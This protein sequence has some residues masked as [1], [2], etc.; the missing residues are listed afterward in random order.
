MEPEFRDSKDLAA[1][2]EPLAPTNC[3]PTGDHR[4]NDAANVLAVCIS[5]RQPI[6]NP[7]P[8]AVKRG[9]VGEAEGAH[10]KKC[11]ANV[12]PTPLL[13][14]QD[15]REQNGDPDDAGGGYSIVS[16]DEDPDDPLNP[17]IDSGEGSA[18][19]ADDGGFRIISDDAD[20]DGDLEVVGVAGPEP[21]RDY[22][23]NREQCAVKQTTFG[24]EDHCSNCFCMVC[25]SLVKDCKDWTEHCKASFS[26]PLWRAV[27]DAAKAAAKTAKA[28]AAAE[29]AL[30]AAPEQVAAWDKRQADLQDRLVAMS[31]VSSAGHQAAPEQVAAWDKRQADLQDRLVAMSTVTGAAPPPLQKQPRKRKDWTSL[32]DALE[33]SV[34]SEAAK[35]AAGQQIRWTAQAVQAFIDANKLSCTVPAARSRLSATYTLLAAADAA[36]T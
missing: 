13:P 31:T 24:T 27:R 12:F 11:K 35:L 28:A 22:A 14:Y 29:P 34:R 4:V 17:D 26:S 8:P 36:P 2:K 1:G 3:Q 15:Q 33:K 6:P 18:G 7:N 19:L 16:D 9:P 23:H 21:N 20:A 30:Q 25:D 5:L 32:A 10:A